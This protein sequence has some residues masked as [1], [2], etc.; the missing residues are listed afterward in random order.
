[1]ESYAYNVS[2]T[3]NDVVALNALQEEILQ[4]AIAPTLDG[5]TVSNSTLTISFDVALSAGEKTI[6]DGV[7]AAHTGVALLH[8]T[9]ITILIP[10]AAVDVG[11]QEVIANDNP[12]IE[13]TEGVTG[14]GATELQWDIEKDASA[15]LRCKIKYIIKE[16]GTGRYLRLIARVKRQAVGTDS[17]GAF[18]DTQ[19]I[20]E[21]ASFTTIGEVFEGV[22]DLDASDMEYGD[23][24]V[25]QIGR[26]GNNDLT[27]TEDDDVDVAIQVISVQVER[28]V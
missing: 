27:A 6:L 8:Y 5:V 26:D 17:S 9:P 25:L 13:F 11:V 19:V 14:Y 18:D 28:G 23:A 3:L 21:A 1:M 4:A 20:Y 22:V 15:K 12:A 24:V 7:V 2:D 10:W 16:C